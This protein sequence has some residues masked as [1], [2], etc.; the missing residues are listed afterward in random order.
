[1]R[2]TLLMLLIAA[3]TISMFAQKRGDI[4]IENDTIFFKNV[5]SFIC[6]G[7]KKARQSLYFISDMDKK[8]QAAIFFS[9]KDT[10]TIC[11]ARFPGLALRYDVTYPPIDLS[12]LVESYYKN[13]VLLN[14]KVDSIGLV[15]YCEEREIALVAMTGRKAKNPVND[16]AMAEAARADYASQVAF[17]IENYSD[18]QFKVR[19]GKTGTSRIVILDA[20]RTIVE[21]AHINDQVCIV[22]N[23]DKVKSCI[24]IKKDV[25]KIVVNKDG[26]IAK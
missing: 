15:K 7:E 23:N 9:E 16:S 1:M 11:T 4:R 6:K 18:Q 26:T 19:I 20:G 10:H 24:D 8:P 13:K 5:P 25:S 2:V 12:V 21:H 14:G 3:S 17:S 22:E